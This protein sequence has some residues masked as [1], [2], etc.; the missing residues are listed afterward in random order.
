MSKAKNLIG[1]VLF[2]HSWPRPSAFTSLRLLTTNDN[3]TI[4]SAFLMAVRSRSNSVEETTLQVPSLDPRF[5]IFI[6]L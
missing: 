6:D 3:R 2:N 5:A 4:I 1:F